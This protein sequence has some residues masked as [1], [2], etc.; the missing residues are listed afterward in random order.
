MR[1][2]AVN[3]GMKMMESDGKGSSGVWW[4]GQMGAIGGGDPVGEAHR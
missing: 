1:C 4:G 2:G 3:K